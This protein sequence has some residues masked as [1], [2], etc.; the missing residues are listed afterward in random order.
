MEL[1][2]EVGEMQERTTRMRRRV[3]N[4]DNEEQLKDIECSV[5][6]KAWGKS[7]MSLISLSG[8]TGE[9]KNSVSITSGLQEQAAQGGKVID[10]VFGLS[11]SRSP[12]CHNILQSCSLFIPP[13]MKICSEFTEVAFLMLTPCRLWC[14]WGF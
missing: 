2:E 6:D 3:K 14:K 7:D 13:L 5:P 1:Q 9:R 4:T 11:F 8:E 12:T 10:P